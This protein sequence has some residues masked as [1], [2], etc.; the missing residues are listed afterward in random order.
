MFTGLIENIGEL[1]GIERH[2]KT[3]KVRVRS[4]LP[5]NEI[6]IGDSVAVNGACLTVECFSGSEIIFHCMAETL[7]RTNLGKASR[8]A[9][10]N[11]ER[12]LRLDSR[13][14][15]HIVSGHV[16]FCAPVISAGMKGDD[17]ELTVSI[18]EGQRDFFVMKGSVALNGVSLTIG[19]LEE[20]AVKVCLIPL[21][22]N[23]TN[24]DSLRK[25]DW[26]NVETDIL[27]KYV[28]SMLSRREGGGVTMDS[29]REAGFLN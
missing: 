16:D 11:L 25:G 13:L 22:R 3:A 9:P 15:G 6:E 29:L 24:L 4:S 5:I 26:V 7:S 12:A 8:G 17:F 21:T 19:G 2:G 10:L 27:G 1:S 28:A 23:K 14:G 18:P 20:D